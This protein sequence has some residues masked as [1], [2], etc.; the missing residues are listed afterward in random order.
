MPSQRVKPYVIGGRGA[1]LQSG[2]KND[3]CKTSNVETIIRKMMIM[4]GG[5][6]PGLNLAI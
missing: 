1:P 2:T 4:I 6:N 5:G 3:G